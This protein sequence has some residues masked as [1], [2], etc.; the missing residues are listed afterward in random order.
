MVRTEHAV[1]GELRLKSCRER[2]GGIE[3]ITLRVTRFF[4]LKLRQNMYIVYILD[5]THQR[6]LIWK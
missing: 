2:D 5:E 4:A 1:A 3:A 6:S